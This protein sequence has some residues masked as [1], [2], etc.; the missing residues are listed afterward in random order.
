MPGSSNPFLKAAPFVLALISLIHSNAWSHER[1][2]RVGIVPQAD[3]FVFVVQGHYQTLDFLGRPINLVAGKT[4]TVKPSEKLLSLGLSTLPARAWLKSQDS[5]AALWIGGRRYPGDF[6]ALLNSNKTVTGIEIIGIETYLL[7]VVGHEM[8]ASWPIEALKAQAVVARTF[9]YFQLEKYHSQGYD[10]GDD[11]GSQVYGG[12]NQTPK[13]I[14]LAVEKTKGEVLGYQGKLL[15]V[16]YHSCCG[17][18]TADAGWVWGFKNTPRPLR[19]VSDPYC[20]FSPYYR[21][22]V[23]FRSDEIKAALENRHLLGGA[24]KFFKIGTSKYDYAKNFKAQIGDVPLS[25]DANRF[26]LALGPSSL[27]SVRIFKIKREAGGLEFSGGGSG[28]GVGLCQW[29]ARGQA[30]RGRS[31]EKILKFYFPGSVL[32]VVE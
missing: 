21:W 13:N 20:K 6:L 7:G 26:R 18:H 25:V 4:Y 11:A 32:S 28:H 12:V 15:S 29:G 2:I 14:V 10:L 23:F 16:Y 19:G 24:L 5:N 9:A 17:G 27:K 3:S 30:M 1:S 8:D 31:Y 22:K